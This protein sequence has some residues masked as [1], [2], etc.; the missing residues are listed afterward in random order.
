MFISVDL[1]VVIS[2]PMLSV[3]MKMSTFSLLSIDIDGIVPVTCILTFLQLTISIVEI[4]LLTH[5]LMSLHESRI[6]E[7]ILSSTCRAR[8]WQSVTFKPASVK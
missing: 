3:D 4:R 2:T 1:L 7:L 5:T 6:S 8:P